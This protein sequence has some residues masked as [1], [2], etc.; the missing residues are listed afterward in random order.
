MIIYFIIIILILFVLLF[1]LTK[2]FE[3]NIKI[4]IVYYVFINKDRDWKYIIES[5]I[6]DII[7]S[8]ILK[9]IKI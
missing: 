7:N 3:N 4:K 8:N 2:N 5:Q 6:N 1:Y 9:I